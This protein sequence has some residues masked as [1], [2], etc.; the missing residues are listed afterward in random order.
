VTA[1]QETV[2]AA[3]EAD[4]WF[5]RNRTALEPGRDPH[6]PVARAIALAGLHPPSVLEIGCSNGYR[7]EALR[8]AGTA[9]A[10]GVEPSAAAI[11]DGH[12]RFPLL[13]LHRGTLDQVPLEAHRR[14]ALVLCHFVLH[15]VSR[16]ALFASLA[17]LDRHVAE[18]GCLLIGDFLPDV[19]TRV[20]YHHLPGRE[21]YTWKQDYA[22][23]FTAT[24]L[25]RE[26]LR[27]SFDHASHTIAADAASD[28]RCAMV[29]LRRSDRKS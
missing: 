28:Q 4:A 21:V 11:A 6:D 26:V 25:Y 14:F 5:T 15:W 18:D 22:L 20:P 24:G 16:P 7:L 13:E 2:F 12:Q 10:V 23:A 1:F 9:L 17:A 29:L 27:F 8:R 3:G 19:P